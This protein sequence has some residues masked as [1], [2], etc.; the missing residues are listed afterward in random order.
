MA[1]PESSDYLQGFRF[2]VRTADGF[3]KYE[4]SDL[5]E[6]GF[7]SCSQPELSAEG[8]EYREGHRTYTMKFP[9][10]PTVGDISLQ[11][12]LTRK[13]T[14]FYAWMF[15][16]VNGGNYRTTVTIYHYPRSGKVSGQGK[17]EVADL[18]KARQTICYQAFPTRVKPGGDLD[19]TSGEVS[20]QEIDIA[21]EYFEVVP[22]P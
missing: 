11:R 19:A 2:M 5:G 1:R 12:G 10:T 17:G 13:D 6:A 14:S 9:G 22:A 7:N 18:S 4:D 21:M 15:Q 8:T 16:V 3:A 20:M